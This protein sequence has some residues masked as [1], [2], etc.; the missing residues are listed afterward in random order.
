MNK[1]I[2]DDSKFLEFFK[3]NIPN[4]I[5]EFAD[6]SIKN[7]LGGPKSLSWWNKN[8]LLV[9]ETIYERIQN[10]IFVNVQVNE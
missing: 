10:K 5:D 8:N 6:V 9:W 3:G 1:S 2:V 4:T 7:K